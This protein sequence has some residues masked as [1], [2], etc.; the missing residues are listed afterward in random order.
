MR[1]VGLARVLSKLG[2]C[3]RSQAQQLIDA[4]RV[5]VNGAVKRDPEAPGVYQERPN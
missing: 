3:S 4:G 2:Y 5:Q 1:T